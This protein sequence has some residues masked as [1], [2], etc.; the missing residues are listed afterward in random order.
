MMATKPFIV[1]AFLLQSFA[2]VHPHPASE[3]QNPKILVPRKFDKQNIY[4]N[5]PSYDQL[6]LDRSYP[7][8]A[9]WGVWVSSLILEIFKNKRETEV[10]STQTM[11]KAP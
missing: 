5:W 11:C 9:A 10:N 2:A 7:N 3:F 8:K 4:K 6:S 1:I